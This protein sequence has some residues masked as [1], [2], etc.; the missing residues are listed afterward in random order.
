MHSGEWHFQ[1]SKCTHHTTTSQFHHPFRTW[2]SARCKLQRA[3]GHEGD[4]TGAWHIHIL[5]MVQPEC[6]HCTLC[7]NVT[8]EVQLFPFLSGFFCSTTQCPIV[9]FT[10]IAAPPPRPKESVAGSHQ[11]DFKLISI[12]VNT[13]ASGWA[14]S[15][16]FSFS[17][18][19]V[20]ATPPAR[21]RQSTATCKMSPV[22]SSCPS[23]FSTIS[24]IVHYAAMW[25]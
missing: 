4:E 9:L 17:P 24:T 18:S 3:K 6:H 1:F 8:V 7:S 14:S 11:W 13:S 22:Q 21:C 12:Y 16:V 2:N 5:R 20:M 15:Y 19:W 10:R 23:Q 25:T